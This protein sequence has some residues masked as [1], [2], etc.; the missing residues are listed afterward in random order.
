VN[1]D[2]LGTA[3]IILLVAFVLVAVFG[4]RLAP[5]G[6]EE[7]VYG[8]D[9]R[10]AR[11]QPPSRQFP[12]G[13][14][15]YAKDVLSQT[16]LG[17]RVAILVGV[18]SAVATVFVGFNVGLIAGYRGGWID[19]LIMRIVDITYGIPFIP[20]AI[21]LVSLLRP[22]VWNII[23]TI[24]LLFW[25]TTARIIRAQ[26]LTLKARPFVTSARASG[27]SPLRIM[28]LHIAP[29]VFPLALLYVALGVGTGVLTEAGLAFLGFGDPRM[30]S[31]GG[32]LNVAFQTGSIRTAWWWV[33]PPGVGIALFVIST[34]L[35]GR[36]YEEIVN[37]RLRER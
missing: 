23:L 16:I 7:E 28:Y 14:T 30:V 37:P 15:Q 11:L 26:V 29:N 8:A 2:P 9:G 32:M 19:D 13:T 36:A 18:L 27:A 20:F 33:I 5:H 21:I 4:H 3:G 22:S 34:F 31:W 25:R 10:L 6:G 17:T 24:S 12:L 1:R 35:V